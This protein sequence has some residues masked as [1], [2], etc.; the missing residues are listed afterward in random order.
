MAMAARMCRRCAGL[1]SSLSVRSCFMAAKPSPG[2]SRTCSNI[3]WV[4][5]KLDASG[6]GGAAF[7]RLNVPS[8]Q[9]T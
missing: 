7:R 4:T 8:S 2:R 9:W 3:A 1:A 5:L 6:S